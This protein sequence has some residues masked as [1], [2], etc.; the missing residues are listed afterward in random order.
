MWANFWIFCVILCTWVFFV[1]LKKLFLNIYSCF[2]GTA[3]GGFSAEHLGFEWTATA[4]AGI[5]I[6]N[7]G[8]LNNVKIWVF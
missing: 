8:V 5:Q 3:V 4:V 1:N 2:I 7:V 6:I